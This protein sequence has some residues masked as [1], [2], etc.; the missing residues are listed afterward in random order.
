MR[1]YEFLNINEELLDEMPLPA[2][3]D[4]KA[5]STNSYDPKTTF[6]SRLQ[7]ALERSKR[8]GAGSSRVAMII[9]YQGRPTVLKIAKNKKGLAQNIAEL[10]FL[11][12]GYYGST[13][14][15]IPLIDFDHTN[16]KPIWIQT[17]LAKKT[18]EK[19]L[20]KFFRCNSLFEL[21][22]A[23]RAKIG[24]ARGEYSIKTLEKTLAKKGFTSEDWDIF[25]GY[26]DELA[27]LGS[28]GVL[29]NDFS[30]P[31]NWGIFNGKPVI[32]DVGYTEDVR[33][34][35]YLREMPVS[36]YKPIGNFN[37]PGPFSKVDRKLV[38]HPKNELKT[39]KLLEKTPYDFRLFFSNIPGTGKYSE[40]GSMSPEKVQEVFGKYSEEILNGHQD[41]ITVVFVGNK[42]DDKVMLTPWMMAHRFGHAINA[43]TRKG[44]INAWHYWNEVES[45]FFNQINSILSDFYNVP[46]KPAGFDYQNSGSYNALFNSIGTQRSSRTNRIRRPYEFLYEMF[47]QYLATGKVTLNPLPSKLNFGRKVFGRSSRSLTLNTELQDEY[48]YATQVLSNDMTILFSDILSGAEGKIFV[49]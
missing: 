32:I 25:M 14:L 26:V 33:R 31:A 40:F 18:N 16:R 23:A 48:K 46:V 27:S 29:L 10:D 47:A 30:R 13:G 43:D 9:E 15:L 12:D 6:K 24:R 42:G 20:C 44:N 37:R 22:D 5:F 39:V 21:T 8:I 38:T 45:H 49:I 41:S 17:E 7:Y 36:T 34:T 4:S 19:E 2:D 1:A 11:Q 28:S 35:H 3:W